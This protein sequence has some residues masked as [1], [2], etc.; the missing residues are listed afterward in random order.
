MF[1]QLGNALEIERA[2]SE[3]DTDTVRKSIVVAGAGSAELHRKYGERTE[4][5]E[6]E[7]QREYSGLG[8]IGNRILLSESGNRFLS[9]V[10]TVSVRT[11]C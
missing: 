3:E 5:T 11:F 7:L 6:E 4:R 9:V 2:R 1:D 10:C 8:E